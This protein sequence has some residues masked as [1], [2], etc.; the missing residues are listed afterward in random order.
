MRPRVLAGAAFLLVASALLAQG[1][2]EKMAKS[3]PKKAAARQ[4]VFL[5]AADVKWTDLDSKGAPGVK[6]ADLWGDHTKGAYG[7]LLKF[8][9][10]FVAPLHTHTWEIRIVVLSGT[11]LQTPDGGTEQRM[12]PGSYVKQPGGNYRHISACDKASECVLFI[13]SAGKF[14]LKVVDQGKKAPAK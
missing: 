9:P 3:G 13:E 6:I 2:A 11:Y 14:D 1:S 4:P 7:A 12:G 5:Q 10:G 8:P